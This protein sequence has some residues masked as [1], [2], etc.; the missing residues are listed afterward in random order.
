M[1]KP[2]STQSI[3]NNSNHNQQAGRDINNFNYPP[4]A[5]RMLIEAYKQESITNMAFNDTV[6]Q[7]DLYLNPS[8]RESGDVIGLEKKLQIGHFDSLIPYAMEAKD[9]FARKFEQHRLSK[10]AQEIFLYVLAD[11]WTIFHQKIY[12][13][14]CNDET[15]DVI[16]QKVQ[17]EIIEIISKKLEDN[18]LK[19]YADCISG[20]IY[21]LTGN[22]HIKWSKE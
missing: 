3:D 1:A 21:F 16:M 19:I 12:L 8:D 4:T 17:D 7:L 13:L 10:A 2:T 18:V 6:E 9:I 14:I 11:I 20:M 5:M 22:C 15:H